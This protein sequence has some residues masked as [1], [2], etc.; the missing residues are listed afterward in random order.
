M[1]TPTVAVA[2][3]MVTAMAVIDNSNGI[4]VAMVKAMA[5]AMATTTA[6]TAMAG[7]TDNSQLKGAWKKQ[8]WR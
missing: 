3:S 6:A 8:R 1:A 2:A 4:L 5:A 7:S